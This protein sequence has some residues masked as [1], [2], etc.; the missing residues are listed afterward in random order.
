MRRALT[1]LAGL[2]LSA[3]LLA[4]P[5]L[6]Q[7]AAQPAM[8]VADSVYLEGD[9]RL[10]AT[11]NVEAF[12][13]GLR[14]TA[15]SI[16]YDQSTDQLV[17]DGPIRII[18]EA[19]N[20]ITA[21]YAEMDQGLRNGLLAG[22]RM[23]L[24]Q[25]LQLASVE[26]RRVN[27][28]YTQ[29]SKVA[30][31]SCQVC[32]KRQV[33]LWQIRASRVVHDQEE[34]QLYFDDAQL[35]VLD[36]PIFYLPRM[37]LPDPTLKRSRGFL[38]P[39]IHSST[40]LGFGIKTPYFFPIGQHQDLT[41]TPYVSPKTR[42]LE[43]RYRR[44]FNAGKLTLE[45][46]VTSDTLKADQTRGYLFAEGEFLVAREFKLSFNLKSVTDDAYLND[47][48]I[49]TADRLASD[50]SLSRFRYNGFMQASILNYET[51]R[52]FENNATQPRFIADYV[53][54]RRYFPSLGG[55]FRFN[56]ETHG[57]L[58]QSKL[59]V[60]GPDDDT[61]VDGRDVAR[62]NAEMSWRN[63]WT[64]A[65]GIRAGLSAHLW[66]DHYLTEQDATSDAEVSR[67]I[68]GL[69]AEFRYPLQRQD[70]RGGRT[71]LE[72]VLQVGWVGGERLKNPNDESTRVEFDEANLLSLSRFPAADRREHGV[73]V[74]A[75]LRWL[76]HAPGGWSAALTLG[77]VWRGTEDA[78][79]SL[80]SGLSGK[81]SDLLIA[82]RFSNP[83]GLS[84]SA[85]GLLDSNAEISKAEARAG[86][87]NTRMDLGASYLLL[88]ADPDED[89]DLTQS[90]WTFDGRYQVN[91]HWATSGEARYDIADRRVDR[92]G[93]GLQ[94]RNECIQVDFQVTRDYASSSNIEPS[95]DFDLTVAL[96]GFGA[97]NSGKEYRRTCS[98]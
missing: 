68:P 33:P 61:D 72:P 24:D 56:A 97:G 15:G 29:L 47:Y 1:Y 51:L 77:K 89:R 22:A 93:V 55:E 23:V 85:R 42:T 74:A 12:H 44:A 19:G 62:I 49:T 43:F 65:G 40:L 7:E 60:D 71:L 73:T 21:T 82:G 79:F 9:S 37:R 13:D 48:D 17:I 14:M 78:D 76:H 95:T 92:L 10:V 41:L 35:R 31:T 8:L 11:G 86:W 88:V 70:G 91:R 90:E 84:I 57:H 4:P 34:R 66:V 54:E 59:D 75:G 27:G 18:D 16:V 83:L 50:V 58:R 3:A 94:Y 30:V 80:S 2:L 46:G 25:Q 53:I 38:I 52:D 96:T 98:F 81:N 36:F 87:S 5:A 20:V 69:A 32:G 63:R 45:G 26:A 6:A 67:A 39:T 28:R 64:L